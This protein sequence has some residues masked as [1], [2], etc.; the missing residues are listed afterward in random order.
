MIKNIEDRAKKQF[1]DFWNELTSR[2]DDTVQR[3]MDFIDKGFH[4]FG[5]A[6]SEYWKCKN[7]IKLQVE[8]ELKQLPDGYKI[9]FKDMISASH[10]NIVTISTRA[11]VEFNIEGKIVVFNNGRITC[12]LREENG[13]LFIAHLHTSFPDVSSEDEVVPGSLKPRLYEI[14]I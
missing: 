13:K 11:L 6:T 8:R 9:S 14:L 4:G 2:E 10:N 12:V 1:E 5:S 3:V 7:D